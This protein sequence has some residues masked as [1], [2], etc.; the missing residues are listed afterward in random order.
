MGYGSE[1]VKGLISYSKN[2]GIE[3][4]IAYVAVENVASRKI[5]E[6]LGFQFIEDTMCKELQIPEK[7]Y[8]LQL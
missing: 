8:R 3:K 2:I 6:K 4:L 5:I 1:V 7:K